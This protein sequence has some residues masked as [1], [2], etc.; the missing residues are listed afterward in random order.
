[1]AHSAAWGAANDAK[2]GK[3][4]GEWEAHAARATIHQDALTEALNEA[5]VVKHIDLM[6]SNAAWGAANERAYGKSRSGSQV[7]WDRYR[8]MAQKVKDEVNNNEFASALETAAKHAAWYATNK[9]QYGEGHE[10]TLH[11]MKLFKDAIATAKRVAPEKWPMKDVEGLFKA[12]ALAAAS[13]RAADLL[14]QK[15]K[16]KDEHHFEMPEKREDWKNYYKY[17]AELQK[18][19]G[20]EQHDLFDHFEGMVVEAALGATNERTK[21]KHSNDAQVH[22]QK[23]KFHA[24]EAEPL[25]K[26][27][28][29]YPD[30][31]TMITEA[32][33][34]AANERAYGASSFD[35]KDACRKYNE[36]A[37]KVTDAHGGEL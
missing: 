21:G 31:K 30:I 20:P 3:D 7:D 37:N 16:R 18:S 6:S 28:A 35:A 5:P 9:Y 29:K 10:D 11:S 12:D 36:A 13:H 25:Y 15:R 33:W 24:D 1:M 17:A 19:L 2:Y 23:Y 34:G 32:A 22:W 27:P 14:V 26:G 8:S 4:M